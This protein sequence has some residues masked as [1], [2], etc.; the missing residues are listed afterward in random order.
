M[1]IKKSHL[2]SLV[3]ARIEPKHDKSG[4]PETRPHAHFENVQPCV[5]IKSKYWAWM[6]KRHAAS[7]GSVRLGFKLRTYMLGARLWPERMAPAGDAVPYVGGSR[8][9]PARLDPR[10]WIAA[11]SNTLAAEQ[12]RWFPWSVAAFGAGIAAY[13]GLSAEPSL[14]I[15][16]IV[17]V[18][19]IMLGAIGFINTNTLVRFA[20]ALVAAAGLG[21]A[22]G[23]LRTER[24]DA[25]I[26]A[27]DTGPVRITG[28]VENVEIRAANRA[29]IVLA[30]LTME[31]S[32]APPNRV[33]LTLIGRVLSKPPCPGPLFQRSPLCGRRPSRCSPTATTSHGG[34]IS[35][36]SGVSDSLTARRN[37]P[38]APRHP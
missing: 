31:D 8:T 28:R 21:F 1:Y 5:M 20:C 12:E 33:R 23:K 26:I 29:R 15:A 38:K 10:T 18:A 37:R 32:D 3:R 9:L 30:T 27:R 11:L 17:V 6:A 35:R 7:E 25:P 14:L 24:V 34:P 36:A 13:F 2:W 16:G 4:R 19:S 22:A